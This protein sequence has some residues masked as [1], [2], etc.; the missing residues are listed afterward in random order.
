M[1]KFESSL[2]LAVKLKL[3]EILYRVTIQDL[4]LGQHLGRSVQT[5][6]I[7]AQNGPLGYG[8]FFFGIA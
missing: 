5:K 6:T 8:R 3:Q 2:L 4:L 7:K 1:T